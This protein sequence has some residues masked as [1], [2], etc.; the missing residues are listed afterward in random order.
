MNEGETPARYVD[1]RQAARADEADIRSLLRSCDLP[2][3]DI[4]HHLPNF[5]V[6]GHEGRI[7]GTIGLEVLGSSATTLRYGVSI[8]P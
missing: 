1:I 8:S 4:G 3:D 2:D 5:V 7:V 6:A